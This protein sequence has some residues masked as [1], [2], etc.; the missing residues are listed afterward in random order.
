MGF[1]DGNWSILKEVGD[2]E[3]ELIFPIFRH[4][5]VVFLGRD[6]MIIILCAIIG[7]I[8]K[9][10][11]SQANTTPNTIDLETCYREKI[12]GD[13]GPMEVMNF[14]MDACEGMT[15]ISNCAQKQCGHY[16]DMLWKKI[17]KEVIE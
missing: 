16:D 11:S 6:N 10:D 14:N 12:V 8:A 4:S 15:L 2:L 17:V 13:S 7:C 9:K 1:L 5:D 3:K